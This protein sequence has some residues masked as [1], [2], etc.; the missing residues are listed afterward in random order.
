MFLNILS[1]KINDK[2]Y[3]INICT[4]SICIFSIQ[5]FFFYISK[6]KIYILTCLSLK[7]ITLN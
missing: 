6:T 7:L 2:F 1:T 4:E 5:F 3:L